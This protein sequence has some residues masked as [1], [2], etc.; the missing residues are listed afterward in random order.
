MFLAIFTV[1]G[2]TVTWLDIISYGYIKNQLLKAVLGYRLLSDSPTCF[3]LA[4]AQFLH[5]TWKISSCLSWNNTIKYSRLQLPL[6]NTHTSI[7]KNLSQ[8]VLRP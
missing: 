1:L 8:I 5:K 3:T 4:N 2:Q 6:W 7:L